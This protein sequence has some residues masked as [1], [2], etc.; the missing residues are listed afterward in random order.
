MPRRPLGG[1]LRPGSC[2]RPHRDETAA[3]IHTSSFEWIAN[4]QLPLEN[5]PVPQVSGVQQFAPGQEGRRNNHGVVNVEPVTEGLS[6]GRFPDLGKSGHSSGLRVR[7][8][9]W[10][11]GLWS[12]AELA[13]APCS[14][15]FRLC[16]NAAADFTELG[17]DPT[18]RAEKAFQQRRQINVGVEL[19]EM[20]P[21]TRG[22]DFNRIEL[23][24]FRACDAL[25]VARARGLVFHSFTFSLRH[26]SCLSLH[27]SRLSPLSSR[28]TPH[29]L[30]EGFCTS[31][32]ASR[33]SSTS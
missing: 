33:K 13:V 17:S 25:R 28:L 20:D 29:F 9:G 11:F 32:I 30:P 27:A 10:L 31:L 14:V 1:R 26:P 24:G 18:L 15:G 22:R 16:R 6:L 3:T 2:G 5:L 23:I 7:C 8:L 21:E 12:S 4:R 19:R